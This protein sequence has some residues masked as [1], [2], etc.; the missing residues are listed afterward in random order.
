MILQRTL[1]TAF[2]AQATGDTPKRPGYGRPAGFT[3]GNLDGVCVPGALWRPE[4]RAS[5]PTPLCNSTQ[6][7]QERKSHA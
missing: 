6:A 1:D 7:Q 5:D 2:R 4:A 3:G